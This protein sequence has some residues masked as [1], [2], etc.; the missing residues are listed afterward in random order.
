MGAAL[1]CACCQEDTK[2]GEEVHEVQGLVDADSKVDA[3]IVHVDVSMIE[4][5]ME[6]FESVPTGSGMSQCS[7]VREPQLVGDDSTAEVNEDSKLVAAENGC[8]YFVCIENKGS[9]IGIQLRMTYNGRHFVKSIRKGV[10]SKWNVKNP[11]YLVKPSDEIISAN[12][13]QQ[14]KELS[15]E[16]NKVGSLKLLMRRPPAF[17]VTVDKAGR[18]FGLNLIE[19]TDNFVVEGV[20]AGSACGLWNRQNPDRE[21]VSGHVVLEVNGCRQKSEILSQISTC[22]HLSIILQRVVS[23]I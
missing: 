11:K 19:E 14:P 18:E 12:G 22:D 3:A 20:V 7:T 16:L 8:D 15:A 4:E 2:K 6:A 10:V 9:G 13:F 23:G 5:G 1:T 21:V 17:K